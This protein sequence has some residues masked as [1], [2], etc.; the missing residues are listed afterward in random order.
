MAFLSAVLK[1][2]WEEWRMRGLEGVDGMGALKE[3]DDLLPG[4]T[5]FFL[6][7]II[8][9]DSRRVASQARKGRIS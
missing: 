5:K 8:V 6:K 3:Q 1:R 4:E 7:M 2:A 9:F